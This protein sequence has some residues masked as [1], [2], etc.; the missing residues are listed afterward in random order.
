MRLV[1]FSTK[2]FERAFFERIRQPHALPIL[3]VEARLNVATASIV[4]EGDIVCPFVNDDLS[5]EVLV[6]LAQHGVT[7]IAMR[8]AGYNNVDV[9]AAREL[10]FSIARVAAYSPHAVAEH[11]IAL[12]LS[13]N[14]KIHRAHY[15]ARELNFS[16][17]GLLGFD[18]FRKT[19]GVVGTGTIGAVVVSILNGLGCRILAH[20]V[21]PDAG[22]EALGVT[23]V[24]LDT[25]FR[26]SDIITLHCP[27]LPET[28]HLINDH[29][30]SLMKKGVMLI[31][32]SRGGLVDTSAAIRALKR[33]DLGHLGL[34][35]YE[36][37]AG[38]FFEDLSD[39]TIGDDVFARLL[40]FPNVM[41]TSHQG[42]FTREALDN[43][44][45]TTLE[46][47]HALVQGKVPEQNRV[48]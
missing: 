32:T 17:E 13:L 1:V 36:E 44:V 38:L 4:R 40:T 6:M 12:M 2:P 10:G 23:Y 29:A 15:R 8:C 30:F 37:E 24:P 48:C 7:R 42:F 41:I 39:T 47:C 16:L 11:T 31:N 33:G 19:V 46:N 20:D 27:L 43:I 21:K 26:E 18:M 5:R 25:L 14:R 9:S 3:Y 22:C 28:H 34:D 45:T 35:V